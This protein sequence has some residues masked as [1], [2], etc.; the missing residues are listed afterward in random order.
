[1]FTSRIRLEL[2]PW[3]GT[4]LVCL[5]GSGCSSLQNRKFLSKFLPVQKCRERHSIIQDLKFFLTE[6]WILSTNHPWCYLPRTYLLKRSNAT[7][8]GA[9]GQSARCLTTCC[10][11][12]TSAPT[13]H[14][15]H[16]R[17]AQ[18]KISITIPRNHT[19][20]QK[21]TFS[22]MPP[23]RILGL[24]WAFCTILTTTL[25]RVKTYLWLVISSKVNTILASK[26]LK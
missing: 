7:W 24:S 9:I 18:T 3:N 12:P 17:R 15:T 22:I 4:R 19:P 5:D 6:W 26:C 25:M 2:I 10:P 1:M 13:H 23:D 8:K 11:Y 14:I 21:A 20:H 16:L